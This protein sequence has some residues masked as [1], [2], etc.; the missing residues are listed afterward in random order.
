MSVFKVKK[1]NVSEGQ[2][3]VVVSA[4]PDQLLQTYHPQHPALKS[5]TEHKEGEFEDSESRWGRFRRFRKGFGRRRRR[6]NSH[7]ASG[8]ARLA[9]R[10]NRFSAK[11]RAFVRFKHK[12]GVRLGGRRENEPEMTEVTREDFKYENLHNYHIK[13]D[14]R[15]GA[16]LLRAEVK[17]IENTAGPILE[18]DGLARNLYAKSSA[19]AAEE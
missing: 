6:A 1:N 8:R 17:R 10:R 15:P 9:E 7:I 14:Q 18:R 2:N 3:N 13:K 12:F 16:S 4:T 11:T 19:K 5:D